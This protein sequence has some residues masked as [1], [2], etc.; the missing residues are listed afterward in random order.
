MKRLL[1]VF[2]VLALVSALVSCAEKPKVDTQTTGIASQTAAYQELASVGTIPAGLN[3]GIFYN[4]LLLDAVKT[5]DGYLLPTANNGKG[6]LRMYRTDGIVRWA[7]AIPFNA[8]FFTVE[9]LVALRDGGFAFF[10]VPQ[11]EVPDGVYPA[12]AR[13]DAEGNLL[14]TRVYRDIGTGSLRRLFETADEDLL[15]IGER[16][17]ESG[18]RDILLTKLNKQGIVLTEKLFGDGGIDTLTDA[19]YSDDIGLVAVFY[20]N[21]TNGDFYTPSHA[22]AGH[23]TAYF[24]TSLA[25]TRFVSADL[26]DG[27][28]SSLAVNQT[29]VYILS[30]HY[31]SDASDA[32]PRSTLARLDREGVMQWERVFEGADTELI[33]DEPSRPPA[34]AFGAE[35]LTIDEHGETI[36]RFAVDAG[37]ILK[38]IRD[39]GSVLVLSE[40]IRGVVP[41]PPQ[42][43][44]IWYKTDLVYSGFGEDG[45][46]RW[47]AAF[48][49]T[50]EQLKKQKYYLPSEDGIGDLIAA[51][52][53]SD[54]FE[55]S[56]SGADYRNFT[57]ED[58]ER[59]TGCRIYK[60]IQTYDSYLLY[61]GQVYPAG[62][63]FGGWGVTDAEVCD[64][65]ADSRKE[66]LFTYSWGS[67]L[68]RSQLGHFDPVTKSLTYA[69]YMYQNEDMMLTVDTDRSLV[70]HHAAISYDTEFFPGAYTLTRGVRLGRVILKNGVLSVVE[71]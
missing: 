3:N 60:N 25:L 63:G 36:T 21:S 24:D 44:S 35:L 46:L 58:V 62:I 26:S 66:L 6:G 43:S 59:E 53:A 30:S 67:G 12:V 42:V 18:A 29:G 52:K 56:L 70:L 32:K 48:D 8:P 5:A 49:N 14:W 23:V 22:G 13:C 51:L 47:R 4:K 37:R 61:D 64:L 20:T 31:N 27:Y 11:G 55:G 57:P 34:L 1:V 19:G 50:N 17:A 65:N 45:S 38:L 7:A 41:A 33:A 54:G 2:T 68:H 9:S 28:F 40:H 69:E 39:N 71:D 16:V 15:V 10:L